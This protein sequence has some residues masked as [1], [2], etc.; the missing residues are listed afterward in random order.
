MAPASPALP[1][2]T[3]AVPGSSNEPRTLLGY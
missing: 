1:K 3:A 2:S